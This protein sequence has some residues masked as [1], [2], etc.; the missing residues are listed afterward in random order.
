MRVE[1]GAHPFQP[2]RSGKEKGAAC[3]PSLL[4]L[5]YRLLHCHAPL[6]VGLAVALLDLV[7]GAG[8]AVKEGGLEDP[9]GPGKPAVL[10]EAGGPGI[11]ALAGGRLAE[12]SVAWAVRTTPI[13]ASPSSSYVSALQ[14]KPAPSGATPSLNPE[15]TR[16]SPPGRP[17]TSPAAA[18]EAAACCCARRRARRDGHDRKTVRR[19]S[20]NRLASARGSAHTVLVH[21]GSPLL[22]PFTWTRHGNSCPAAAAS[23][24]AAAAA[25]RV[26]L[27][28][29]QPVV[30][31]LHTGGGG[32]G[33]GCA[34]WALAWV[35][36]SQA[37]CPSPPP[38]LAAGAL[39]QICDVTRE[40]LLGS[41]VLGWRGG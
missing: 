25:S 21:S 7:P 32:G 12:S 38:S 1:E 40:I 15:S 5:L 39:L 14:R 28:A 10:G 8:L 18:A 13:V 33:V 23:A 6:L 30:S 29:E 26:V 31:K 27:G 22:L 36:L 35:W 34:Q 17:F 24:K 37:C 3:R 41:I 20:P 2:C 11:L 4:L 16:S 19:R 9:D